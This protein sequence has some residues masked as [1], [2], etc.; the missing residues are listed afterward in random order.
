MAH[1]VKIF[2]FLG[3]ISVFQVQDEKGGGGGEAMSEIT[4][5][6]Q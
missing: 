5:D 3:A 2:L 6:V 4:T 1:L